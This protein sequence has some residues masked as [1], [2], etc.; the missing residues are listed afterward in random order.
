MDKYLKLILGLLIVLIGLY[1]Y[2]AWPSNLTSLWTII[3][4]SFGLGVIFVGLI[5]ILLGFTE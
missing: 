3:K 1:T 5:F 2:I 4:G